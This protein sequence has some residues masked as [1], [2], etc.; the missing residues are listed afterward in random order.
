MSSRIEL[1][2]LETYLYSSADILRGHV[3]ASDY[4]SFV[5]PLLFFKRICD[6]YDEENEKLVEEYGEEGAAF[7]GATAHR[8][9]IPEGH[10][11]KDVRN[12]TENIG[13]AIVNAFYEVEQANEDKKTHEKVLLGVFGNAPWANKNRLPDETL[14]NLIE[15]FSTKTLSLTNCPEDELGQAYEYLIKKF[16]DDSG[17]TSQEFYTN[18]TVVHLM[19]EM[20]KPQ[21]G[22][23]VYDP[24]C[25]SAG[26]MISCIAYLKK[27]N[28][29]WRSVKCYGQEI[30][31]LSASIGKMNLFLHGVNDFKIVNADTLKYPAFVENG[32][33]KQFDICLANPPYSISEWGRDSFESDQYGRNFLGTPPQGRADYAFFQHILASLKPD[34]GR[35]AILFPHGVLTRNDEAQMRQKLVELDL[36]EAVIG[37]GKN[38]FFNSPMEACVVICRTKKDPE[39]KGKILFINAKNEITRK[40]S[41][42]YLE[43]EHI[44]RIANTYLEFKN[45]DG[46]SY[47]ATQEEVAKNDY[48]LG[49]PKYVSGAEEIVYSREQVDEALGEW[50]TASSCMHEEY[51]KIKFMISGE[52][53]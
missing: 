30:N 43:D 41:Q 12:T 21:P 16:G 53:L 51:E 18:R 42:S 36:V 24:T 47:A 8:F 9:V 17:H 48:S 31:P 29:E 46:F 45:V 23:T 15:H 19:T 32:R 20:L 3:D 10:H 37:I 22:E 33:L 7:M 4:K 28:L 44:E 50:M 14:K 34:S 1:N 26:M 35:C 27:N 5:F 49:I 11:W 40:N 13:T 39:R 6:I 25:G 38:L 2:E 52:V